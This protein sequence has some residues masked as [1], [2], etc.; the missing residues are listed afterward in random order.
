MRS[1]GVAE[2]AENQVRKD[3]LE[4]FVMEA[5][6]REGVSRAQMRPRYA[7]AF[8]WYLDRYLQKAGDIDPNLA[9]HID[10]RSPDEVP[11]TEHPPTL[12]PPK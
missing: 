7:A 2:V 6:D 12:F 11:T 10:D 9:G 8:R 3:V 5:M 4:Q 1:D